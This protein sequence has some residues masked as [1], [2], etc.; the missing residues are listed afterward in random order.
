MHEN[1]YDEMLG[2]MRSAGR[3]EQAPVASVG[4]VVTPPPNLQVSYN[5]ILLEPAETYISEYLLSGYT[6]HVVGATSFAGGGSGDAAYESHNH[7]VDNDETWTDTLKVRDKVAVLPILSQDEK[8]RS[9]R[10]YMILDKLVRPDR[11]R[12]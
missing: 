6:R 5:G 2:L 3:A 1:P 4:T 10:E 8:G 9:K 11:R 12:F 7:P